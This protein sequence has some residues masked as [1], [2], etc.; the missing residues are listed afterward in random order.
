MND[1][2][3]PLLLLTG[4]PGPAPAAL[5]AGLPAE[6]AVL[7][8]AP[9]PHGHTHGAAGDGCVACQ[10]VGPLALALRQ[11][12]LD[13]V[14]SAAAL[15]VAVV[16]VADGGPADEAAR[17]LATDPFVAAR[18]AP[19]KVVCAV[20]AAAGHDQ[21]DADPRLP[22][23]VQRAERLALVGARDVDPDQ[24]RYLRNRLLALNPAAGFATEAAA[25]SP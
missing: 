24:A 20:D 8:H 2:R 11:L 13:R 15:P 14:R 3:I 9:S 4:L 18:F 7:H 22:A 19:P 6:A 1:G 10:A 12:A 17:T 21:L 16:A 23:L 25:L 5:L